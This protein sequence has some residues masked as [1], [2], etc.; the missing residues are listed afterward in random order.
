MRKEI[1]LDKRVRFLIPV[2][3]SSPQ[4]GFEKLL[5]NRQMVELILS[6][7]VYS[8]ETLDSML[9]RGGSVDFQT[10]QYLASCG[11][12]PGMEIGEVVDVTTGLDPEE[13]LN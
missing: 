8:R 11:Y 2:W 7:G 5:H 12:V 9:N 4:R 1:T 6:P 3:H 13:E 10:M